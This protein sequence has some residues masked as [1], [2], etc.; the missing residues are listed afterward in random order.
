MSTV[1]DGAVDVS[2]NQSPMLAHGCSHG[3]ISSILALTG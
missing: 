1:A 3:Q 2:I